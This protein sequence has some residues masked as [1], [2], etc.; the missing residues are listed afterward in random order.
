MQRLATPDEVLA[1]WRNAG[2]EKWFSKDEAFDQDCR[3]RFMPTYEAAARGD[4]NEWELT[5]EGALAVILLLDQFPRNMF[6]GT[7][8]VYKTDP[9]ALMAADR[10]IERGFDRKVQ[11]ELRRFFYLPF[12]HSE[13]LRHQER[14]VALNE[15][16]GEEDSI[17]W[18]R[19]HHDIIA[20]FGRF[21]HR[22]VILR[23]ETTPDEEAFLKESDFRG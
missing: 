1:F 11:P 16:L 8:Q 21:P 14:S 9:V 10:A 18:A 15:A 7:R 13:S 22:N 5:P 12:M 17:K 19:H 20:R 4:L 3:D 23:R 6:R 2:P